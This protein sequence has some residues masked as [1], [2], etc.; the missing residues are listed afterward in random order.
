[1][2][3][4]AMD[5]RMTMF[6]LRTVRVVIDNLP[7]VFLTQPQLSQDKEGRWSEWLAST[8]SITEYHYQ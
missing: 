8:R 4:L 5:K 7:F 1:M 6:T 3:K 2:V